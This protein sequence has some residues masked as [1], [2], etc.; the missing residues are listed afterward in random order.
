MA[1]FRLFEKN[2][3]KKE[4]SARSSFFNSKKFKKFDQNRHDSLQN[5]RVLKILYFHVLIS[6]DLA[7]RTYGLLPLEQHHKIGKNKIKTPPQ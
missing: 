1:N 4:N 7:K 3:F 6:P 5:A 2:I